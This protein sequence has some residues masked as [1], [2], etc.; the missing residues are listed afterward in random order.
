[1][2]LLEAQAYVVARWQL[3]SVEL[4]KARREVAARRWQRIARCY[5]A[6]NG[7]LTERQRQW[8]AVLNA[9]PRAA[10]AGRSAAAA[11]GLTGWD[12]GPIHVIVPRGAS[13]PP[14]IEG[15]KL[16]WTR[17]LVD[18]HPAASLPRVRTATALVQASGWMVS[19]RAAM[20]V[21]AA[22]VQQRLVRPND[23]RAAAAAMRELRRGRLVSGG[24]TTCSARTSW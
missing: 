4:A 17:G 11:A 23:L 20:G 5:V 12:D 24:A 7:P 14:R 9:G 15:V 19:D 6:Q 18:I 10:L 16:R 22:G 2:D 8:V 1:M 13:T 21:L 3:T